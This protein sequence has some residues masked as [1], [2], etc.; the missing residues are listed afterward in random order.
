MDLREYL[1]ILTNQIRCKQARSIVEE[2]M[3]QHIE[4]QAESFCRE[5]MER[6]EAMRA[7]VREMGD[8]VETGTQLDRIHRPRM[9]WSVLI[10][11]GIMSI[12]GLVLQ[13]LF[14]YQFGVNEAAHTDFF[15]KQVGYT[16]VGFVLMLIVYRLDY[17]LL[18]KWQLPI[19]A[20]FFLLYLL[21]ASQ[22]VMIHYTQIRL[23]V[24]ALGMLYIPVYAGVLFHFRG[25]GY[26]QIFYC[27][28][29]LLFPAAG[30]RLVG[31][32]LIQTYFIPVI[33]LC[34]AVCR[35]WFQVKR[36]F[37]LTGVLGAAIVL[38]AAILL[39][40]VSLGN[41]VNVMYTYQ[42]ARLRALF[43]LIT[44]DTDAANYL[45]FEQWIRQLLQECR[46]FGQADFPAG[47]TLKNLQN[48]YVITGLF[49]YYGMLAGLLLLALIFLFLLRVFR[50]AW[51]QKNQLGFMIGLSCALLFLFQSAL[52]IHSNLW[53]GFIGQM[54]MP[55]LSYGFIC[56]AV[57]FILMGIFLSVHRGSTIT[58]EKKIRRWK[59]KVVRE[60]V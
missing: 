51:K 15:V 39:L 56:T 36:K 44:G 20:G 17:T 43:G 41:K 58:D 12:A 10:L 49:A 50:V 60:K 29:I 35:G 54:S 45:K 9:E 5:G 3:K 42:I 2:E 57:N 25:G 30:S 40:L 11:A 31:A 19:W 13:Y 55:F 37:A 53:G 48:E 28:L 22:P 46:I 27:I 1:D 52:Y 4:D 18:A 8:P 33:L 34:V 7:A 23:L 59:I 24:Y 38:P 26:L 21:L 6:R 14:R 16:A 32:A 47:Y